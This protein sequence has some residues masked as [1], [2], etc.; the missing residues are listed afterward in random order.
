[1]RSSSGIFP[2]VS[3]DPSVN[4]RAALG[5]L[6][7]ASF[8]W[9]GHPAWATTVVV[10]DDAATIQAGLGLADTVLVRSGMY[11]ECFL[12]NATENHPR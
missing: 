2:R 3:V 5:I 10:P 7:V 6:L 4:L 12:M 9:G 8:G 1:M 11:P